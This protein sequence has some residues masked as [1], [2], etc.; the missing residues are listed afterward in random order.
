MTLKAQV[1]LFFD[2]FLTDNAGA[3]ANDFNG[4]IQWTVTNGSV[5]LVGG[6]VPGVDDPAMGGRF[7][8]LAGSSNDPGEFTTKV[9]LIF[10]A[11]VTYNLSF[12]YSN[13][14]GAMNQ[15]T[16]TIGSQLFNIVATNA[17]FVSFSQDFSFATMTTAT[18]SFLDLGV[19]MDNFG[20]GIDDVQISQVVPEPGPIALLTLGGALFLARRIRRR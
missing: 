1:P 8:D 19:G 12:V 20:V 16:A 18:L 4:F 11:G 15:A 10:A 9:P 17:N 14:G 13:T 3:P 2:G 7:V 5:D 6:N